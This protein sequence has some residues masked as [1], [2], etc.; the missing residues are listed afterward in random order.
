MPA[1]AVARGRSDDLIAVASIAFAPVLRVL[2]ILWSLKSEQYDDRDGAAWRAI[3]DDEL[4]QEP[5]PPLTLLM[6]ETTPTGEAAIRTVR[7]ISQQASSRYRTPAGCVQR[8]NTHLSDEPS[9]LRLGQ[10]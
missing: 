4:A 3:A 2:A 5:T 7:P 10:E 6:L 9:Q 1:R 8:Y